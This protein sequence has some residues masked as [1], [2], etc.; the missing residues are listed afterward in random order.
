MEFSEF[1]DDSPAGL[2]PEIMRLAVMKVRA[3]L[4]FVMRTASVE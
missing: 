2:Q 1:E 3:K 4:D